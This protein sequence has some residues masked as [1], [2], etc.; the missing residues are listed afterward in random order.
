MLIM[1]DK[2]GFG[3]DESYEKIRQEIKGS[4][5]FR[6]NWFL[7]SRN[8]ND[9][10]KRCSTLLTCL[11]KENEDERKTRTKGP[12]KSAAVSAPLATASKSRSRK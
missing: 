12:V 8:A 7:K 3:N 2:F 1:L 4:S 9:I 5:M 6:F 10:N 11:T